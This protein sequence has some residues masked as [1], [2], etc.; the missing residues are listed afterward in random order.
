MTSRSLPN[1]VGAICDNNT[2]QNLYIDKVGFKNLAT[3][4]PGVISTIAFSL[5]RD[6]TDGGYGVPTSAVLTVSHSTIIGTYKN[7][8]VTIVENGQ[9]ILTHT[10]LQSENLSDLLDIINNSLIG[11]HADVVSGSGATV[12][13]TVDEN[14]AITTITTYPSTGAGYPAS[15]YVTL[16][17]DDGTGGK[18]IVSTTVTGTI[19]ATIYFVPGTGYTA[20]TKTTTAIIPEIGTVK[21]SDCSV[22]VLTLKNII[23]SRFPYIDSGFE[24]GLYIATAT[25]CIVRN[26]FF[27]NVAGQ[28]ISWRGWYNNLI[29]NNEFHS[30]CGGGAGVY[31]GYTKFVNN[32]HYLGKPASSIVA[33]FNSSASKGPQTFLNN[34]FI[35]DQTQFYY[36]LLYT[37]ADVF[38]NNICKVIIPDNFPNGTFSSIFI[39]Y[40]RTYTEHK[41][42]IVDN[43]LWHVVDSAGNYASDNNRIIWWIT[44]WP[45]T[46][47]DLPP[48]T[49]TQS[50]SSVDTILYVSD[51]SVFPVAPFFAVV[52]P[53]W[54]PNNVGPLSGSGRK[55]EMVYVTSVDTLN[56]TLTATRQS[57]YSY[58]T[59]IAYDTGTYVSYVPNTRVDFRQTDLSDYFTYTRNTFSWESNSSSK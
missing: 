2:W 47:W 18:I 9:N 31:D 21:L 8:T 57:N 56:K 5:Y 50:A 22:D 1:D 29:Y 13:I 6:T 41:N 27:G 52:S 15:S 16:S 36:I 30:I 14:G 39:I 59:A 54:P 49:L 11:Y 44:L 53:I 10:P 42:S 3:N 23:C 35:F 25:N 28:A 4:W 37:F 51:L 58:G 20:G 19:S 32:K 48:T 40:P 34:T 43:N 24:H 55:V 17:V 45:T 38:K 12:T 33:S 46:P 7:V 26:N